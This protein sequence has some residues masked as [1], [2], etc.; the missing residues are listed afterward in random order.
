MPSS[1]KRPRAG[2]RRAAQATASFLGL[3]DAPEDDLGWAELAR[4]GLPSKVIDRLAQVL[5]WTREKLA[6]TLD[7]VPRTLARRLENK[8]LLTTPESERMLRVARVLARA[9]EV[10]EGEAKASAWI[11]QPNVALG[12]QPPIDLL[13]T[14]I[15]TELVLHELTKI[16]YGMWP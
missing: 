3:K 12:G 9:S 8:E 14:D 11:E 7:L 13:R 2:R 16:D 1:V 4:A 5:G 10:L 15:G 6:T